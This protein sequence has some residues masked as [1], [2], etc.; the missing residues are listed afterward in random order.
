MN[1]KIIIQETGEVLDLNKK[2][3]SMTNPEKAQV[4]S[5]INYI[6]RNTEKLE[7]MIKDWIKKNANLEFDEFDGTAFFENWKLK[8]ISGSRF[9]ESELL[10]NGTEDEIKT[11]GKLK[12]KYSKESSYIKFS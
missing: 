4:L 5:Q 11:W 10:K 3:E 6:R 12:S 9:S 2:I 7:K 8:T 1:N